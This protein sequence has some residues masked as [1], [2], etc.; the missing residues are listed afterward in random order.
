MEVLDNNVY[1][2]KADYGYILPIVL[3]AAAHPISY[4]K[5]LI[6]VGHEPL[7]GHEGKTM[8]GKNVIKLPNFIQYA[9]HIKRVDGWLGLYR[10]LGPRIVHN[11]MSSAVTNAI[12]RK[13]S[14]ENM[15]A[16]KLAPDSSS[17]KGFLH[18][19]VNLAV[20]KTFGIVASYPFHLISVRMMVQFIGH[21][22]EYKS[23]LSSVKEIYQEEGVVGFFTGIV[24]YLIGELL[25][26]CMLRSFN[27]IVVNYVIGTEND[28][29]LEVR[30]YTR[31]ISQY[32]VSMITYPFQLITNIM[33]INGTKLSAG[34]PPLMPLYSSWAECWIDL[35]KKGLRSRG[36]ALFRRTLPAPSVMQ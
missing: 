29:I 4:I 34:R 36:S 1:K 16:G 20:A 12:N 8:F 13:V 23:V 32:F 9:A 28:H 22:T 27:Y 31:G 5:V 2:V 30:S 17:I 10:G 33:A 7:P 19:T 35:G 6:Q 25:G 11:I 21:E 14:E 24:P 18:E 3:N 26:L 15:A